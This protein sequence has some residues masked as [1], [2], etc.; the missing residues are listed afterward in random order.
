MFCKNILKT[1][2]TPTP[3]KCYSVAKWVTGSDPGFLSFRHIGICHFVLLYS[4]GFRRAFGKERQYSSDVTA[5]Y[6][7]IYARYT[8]YFSRHLFLVSNT[9]LYVKTSGQP[10]SYAP[11]GME[12]QSHNLTDYSFIRAYTNVTETFITRHMTRQ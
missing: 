8:A 9:F 2:S 7:S 1:S 3:P 5:S 10:N 6:Y 11:L 4:D 12:F